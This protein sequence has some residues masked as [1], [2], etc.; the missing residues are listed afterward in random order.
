VQEDGALAKDKGL[1]QVIDLLKKAKITMQGGLSQSDNDDT[2]GMANDIQNMKIEHGI[3]VKRRGSFLLNNGAEAQDYYLLK[4]IFV[5]GSEFLIAV[6][7]DR[8]VCA[9]FKHFSQKKMQVYRSH[10][11]RNKSV[12]F[13][14]GVK[15]FLIT[16]PRGY[17][18]VNEFGDAYLIYSNGILK[19]AGGDT[20][21]TYYPDDELSRSKDETY[22]LYL[23]IVTATNEILDSFFIVEDGA[24]DTIP[25]KGD[26]RCAY[27]NEA[28]VVSKL[29]DSQPIQDYK[30]VLIG[31]EKMKSIS[32]DNLDIA[33]NKYYR[34]VHEYISTHLGGEIASNEVY[35]RFK[36]GATLS[37]T[38]TP[39][40]DIV[41]VYN[42]G[43]T[44][45]SVPYSKV[46]VAVIVLSNGNLKFM[47]LTI[48]DASS[49]DTN[50]T[51]LNDL[52]DNEIALGTDGRNRFHCKIVGRIKDSYVTPTASLALSDL[53]F[54]EDGAN[55][56]GHE[57][58]FSISHYESTAITD[59]EFTSVSGS[60]TLARNTLVQKTTSANKVPIADQI[61]GIAQTEVSVRQSNGSYKSIYYIDYTQQGDFTTPSEYVIDESVLALG[62][63]KYFGTDIFIADI[64]IDGDVTD[65]DKTFV[66]EYAVLSKEIFMNY[67]LTH[68]G[69]DSWKINPISDSLNNAVNI[70]NVIKYD[71]TGW[72]GSV[73]VDEPFHDKQFVVWNEN[74]LVSKNQSVFTQYSDVV[75]S[76]A[77]TFLK[78]PTAS[79]SASDYVVNQCPT[80]VYE[81]FISFTK[82]IYQTLRRQ[83]YVY[84]PSIDTLKDIRDIAT[85]GHLLCAIRSNRVWIGRADTLLIN[86]QIELSGHIFS[87]SAFSDGF[88][89]F[90]SA[91]AVHLKG[92][93]STDIIRSMNS[94]SKDIVKSI[95]NDI[96]NAVY[97]IDTDGAIH[98]VYYD[99]SNKV[100]ILTSR[101]ITD[102]IHSVHFG[103]NSEMVVINTVL[104]V[105]D[106]DTIYGYE[107]GVWTTKM[108]FTGKRVKKL[109]SLEGKLIAFFYDVDSPD[110]VDMST[111]ETGGGM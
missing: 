60:T 57:F 82:P 10:F 110:T 81:K 67:I 6:D 77:D 50:A 1:L 18:I 40:N 9:F 93:M 7:N 42:T 54:V 46:R 97:A 96:N 59:I 108:K 86:K 103:K 14:R 31:M 28:G 87:V 33:S 41:T 35:A 109:A 89:I 56:A 64:Y 2:Q 69:F 44:I 78:K 74:N 76:V 51:I 66:E 34:R 105:S 72:L 37:T 88:A 20:G 22:R 65:S 95:S 32:T 102:T 47:P 49:G 11:Q 111:S 63:G 45:S 80:T 3:A 91:G 85:N 104:Y 58:T 55:M 79:G 92:D 90:T 30:S 16:V 62:D 17:T 43:K 70:R 4:N 75:Y 68:K 73:S 100:A 23:D 38:E 39:M 25:L 107:T 94:T 15:F 61:F 84:D 36:R 98:I 29:S 5:G 106:N 71:A 13:E 101:V 27:I 48:F 52:V 53:E 8:N 99:L 24:R 26:V 12:S 19:I 83:P 21:A